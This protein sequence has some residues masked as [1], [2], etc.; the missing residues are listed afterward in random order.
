MTGRWE[1]W[2]PWLRLAAGAAIVVGLVRLVGGRPFL[3]GLRHTSGWTLTAGLVLTL[4][5]T[6][7]ST[8]R[9]RTVAGRLQVELPWRSAL[10]AYYRSQLLNATLPGGILGDVHR[11]VRHGQATGALGRSVRAV[12]WERVTGQLVQLALA[13]VS[14]VVLMRDAAVP[15]WLLPLASVVVVA[16]VAGRRPTWLP[17]VV[18][19]LLATAGYVLMVLVATSAAGV[20]APLGSLIPVAVVMLAGSAIPTNVAGWGPREGAAA[21]AFSSIGVGVDQGVTVSVVYGVM[22]LVAALPGVAVLLRGRAPEAREA[23]VSARG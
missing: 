11:A 19:S 23:P 14:V 4:G 2:W 6:L 18:A 16:V 8:W 20:T 15:W 17:V 22:T 7:A 1:R 3:D 9:W 12:W 10:A 13:A 21:W 5:T